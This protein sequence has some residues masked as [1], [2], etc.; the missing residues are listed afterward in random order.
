MSL[1]THL[2]VIIEPNRSTENNF[3]NMESSFFLSEAYNS[4]LVSVLT[5]M[6]ERLDDFFLLVGI[7]LFYEFIPLIKMPCV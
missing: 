2:L 4:L 7:T 6:S 3:M 5:L 1:E